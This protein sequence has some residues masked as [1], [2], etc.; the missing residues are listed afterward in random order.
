V[1]YPYIQISDNENNANVFIPPTA[2]VVKNLAF[3]DNIAFPWFATAGYE[4]GIV[5]CIRT[6]I[7]LDQESRDILDPGRI[8]PL[9]TFADVG[10][11]IWGNRNLQIKDSAANKLNIRRLLLQARRLIISVSNRLLFDPNDGQIRSQFLSAV[12]PILENI[13][14]ERGLTDFRV[15]LSSDNIDSDRDTLTGKIFLKPTPSLEVIELEFTVT[16]TSVSFDNLS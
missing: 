15:A 1:Y 16:P 5:N 3:T 2:E 7:Q 11:V 6:R 8:N 14:K 4:R 13:R 9:A 12:N 10:V